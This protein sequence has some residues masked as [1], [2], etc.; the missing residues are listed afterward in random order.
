[1]TKLFFL[2]I[3]LL[4]VNL[5]QSISL[6]V[7]QPGFGVSPYKNE[8]IR[9]IAFVPDVTATLNLPS[10]QSFVP[11]KPTII[12]FYALPNGN[13][14]DHTVG[15]ILQT[16]DDW[17]YD[18]QHIGAQTRF[19]RE[20]DTSRNYITIYLENAQKSW[21]AWRSQYPNNAT[22]INS[23]IDTLRNMFGTTGTTVHLSGHSGGGSFIFG[24]LNSVTAIP[25]FI[26]RITFL[27]SNYGYDDSYGPK[28]V[29][30]LNSSAENYLCVLAYNDSVALYNGQP[31]VSPTGG[32]WYRS[33]MMQRYLANHYTFQES[34]DTVFIKYWTANGRIR[35]FLKQNPLRIILHTVQVELNGFIQCT[36]S[37]SENEGIGYTYYGQRAYSSLIQ[38]HVYYPRGINIPPRPPGS[39]T[40]SQFMNFVMNM[41]FAQREAEILKELNKGNIPQFMRSAK[42]IN[43]TFN[44]AQGRSYSVGYD[45]LP[46]Y[47][48][49][50]SDSD[51]CRIP[52][53]PL[54]AQRIADFYGAT[55]PTS[56]LVDN[57]YLKSELKLAPVTYAPVGNQN[58]LVP[59]FI[60]HNNAIENQRIS[61]GA[62]LG[63][64][65][66]GTKKDVVISNKI[67]D[68]AR[69]NHVCIY[70]W[71]SLNGQPIQPLT[72]IHVNTYVDYSHGVRYINNQVTLD[73][74]LVD[75]RLILQDPLKYAIFSN[76]SGPMVQPSYLSDTSRPAVPKSFG[77]RSHPGGSIRLDVPSDSNVTKYRVL[78]GKSGTAFTDTVELTP[79]NLILSG[80]ESDS[81]YFFKIASNNANGYSVNSELLAATA[82]ISSS[83]KSL[84]VHAFDRATTG[85]G[86][87]FIRFIAKGIHL[88]GGKIESCSNEAVTS[89]TFN[90]NDFDRV[91]WILGDESTVD[92]TFNTTEQ[93]KVISYLRSG[94]NFFVS[95]SEIGWDLDSKG[96][97]ADKEFIRSYLKCYF[98]ADAP[99]NT[100]GS[101]YRAEGVNEIN[102]QGLVTHWFDDGTH[103]TINVRWPDVLRPING[104]TGF[105]KYYG[106]DTLNGFAGIYFSGIFPGG[107]VPGSVIVLGYPIETVYPEITRNYLMSKISV[108]FD[109][110]SP[111]RES[112]TQSG[113]DYQ[114]MQ[115]FPNP[116]NY[117]TS[118]KYE[119]KED[120]SVS[121][122]IYNSL[123]EIIYNSGEAAKHRGRHELEVKMDEYPS[124]VYFYQIKANAIGNKDFFV[125]T[126]KMLLVK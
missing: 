122:M 79:Q 88:S 99:N 25:S 81:L 27:D 77:I 120:A 106:Y 50:G 32:T 73:T 30:W 47:L 126:K 83:N 111:V 14:T 52:M 56:K 125:S 65:I 75:I 11:T 104:G 53:G 60:E 6:P 1:M 23:I 44:D 101:I 72:N 36:F 21:P 9:K 34:V 82:G 40:G 78:Y 97:T 95:G 16:G 18:I 26:K 5:A 58:E 94:G 8:Q 7:V 43:T 87:D 37:G 45:V 15:K 31:I 92:E 107:T 29:N 89:G 3:A 86:Y 109:N 116:F 66:G 91:Y 41:T 49:I 76:E 64:L 71:H 84:I 62:P 46:D 110:I 35:F 68:P 93:I 90:L 112:Q 13:T 17:H 4:N 55:M 57:I 38:P 28:F 100:A 51:Y 114:L 63:T 39:M 10:P 102:W 121:L 115:N 33:K 61:A 124:G 96:T 48:A 42:R 54:T 19:V 74:S 103:G 69:P 105:M 70:G 20:K 119:L 108:F 85:N 117:S 118:I 24:Y 67:T 113:V 123:G 59:K 22:I 80:L 98:V 12:T 2:I